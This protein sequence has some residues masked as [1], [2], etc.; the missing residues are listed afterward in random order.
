MYPLWPNQAAWNP[1]A[2][3]VKPEG[4]AIPGPTDEAQLAAT[5]RSGG[6]TKTPTT[7]ATVINITTKR[8]AEILATSHPPWRPESPPSFTVSVFVQFS[9]GMTEPSSTAQA[10][11]SCLVLAREYREPREHGRAAVPRDYLEALAKD[12]PHELGV[13]DLNR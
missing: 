2:P 7:D 3:K 5:A 6:A 4:G 13:N 1:S 8:P 10:G 9:E 11:F 12:G